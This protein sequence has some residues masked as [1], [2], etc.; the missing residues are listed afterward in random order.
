MSFSI[1]QVKV[2]SLSHVRLF[3]TPW[4][5][6]HRLLCPWN[7][8]GKNTG[9]G[10]HSLLQGSSQPRDRTQVSCIAGR[11]FTIWVTREPISP[12]G[13]IQISVF[14]CIWTGV[15]IRTTSITLR[16]EKGKN[17]LTLKISEVGVASDSRRLTLPSFFSSFPFLKKQQQQQQQL[18]K[19][20]FDEEEKFIWH[21]QV[22]RV[23][24]WPLLW[25]RTK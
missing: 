5:V 12:F 21:W 25:P 23:R 8:P 16:S 4:A 1:W 19:Q 18:K 11:F 20:N 14:S 22:Y 17:W 2:K 3:V 9:V 6:V 15:P 13:W 24:E 10:S 7:S